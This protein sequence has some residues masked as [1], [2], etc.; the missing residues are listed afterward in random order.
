MA[1]SITYAMNLSSFKPLSGG[2][3]KRWKQDIEI[4]LGLMDLDLAL[5]EDELA[6]VNE[7]SI[8]DQRLKAEKWEKAN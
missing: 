3:F 6:A 1:S 5:C 8:A 4:V 2:N 7:D